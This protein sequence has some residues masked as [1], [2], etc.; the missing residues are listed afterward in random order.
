MLSELYVGQWI[1]LTITAAEGIVPTFYFKFSEPSFYPAIISFPSHHLF[2]RISPRAFARINRILG[3][4]TI[5]ECL[6]VTKSESWLL[7]IQG[8]AF[9]DK[10]CLIKPVLFLRPGGASKNEKFDSCGFRARQIN[11]TRLAAAS[12]GPGVYPRTCMAALYSMMSSSKEAR[13]V[14]RMPSTI[15]R[16]AAATRAY[17]DHARLL[18]KY[19]LVESRLCPFRDARLH[20]R[21]RR[22]CRGY[23]TRLRGR[24]NPRAT[25]KGR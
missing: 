6:R 11:F 17:S 5:G 4:R 19:S 10:F 21:L 3:R 22:T 15:Y 23:K 16:G 18:V 2:I 20:P 25:K 12:R 14:S 7:R 9:R 1:S 13:Q 8:T 24:T